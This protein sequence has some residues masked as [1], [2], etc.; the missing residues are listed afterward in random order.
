MTQP[1]KAELVVIK[2][3]GSLLA[4][5]EGLLK[6]KQWLNSPEAKALAKSR[7]L[8]VGGGPIVD[9]LRTIDQANS[10]SKT[11]SHWAAINLLET[12]AALASSELSEFCLSDNF[13]SLKELSKEQDLIFAPSRFLREQESQLPGLKLS[14]GWDITSDS[15][16]ARVAEILVAPLVLLKSVPPDQ[17][18]TGDWT[19]AASLGYVDREF[20]RYAAKIPWVQTFCPL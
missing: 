8:I 14:V 12:T 3:G 1:H 2:V 4:T 15:I 18:A 19:T 16:A 5:K 6:L 7:I 20:P 10:L 17:F 11:I 13:D 9:G